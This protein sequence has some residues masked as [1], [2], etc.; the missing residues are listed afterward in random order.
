MKK[1]YLLVKLLALAAALS[2]CSIHHYIAEDY[3]QYLANNQG[4][5][6]L[7]HATV[8]D[9]SYF[10]TPNTQQHKY[11][12]RSA[13][14]GYANAWVVEFGKMLDQTLQGKDVQDAFGKLSKSADD[15][16]PSGSL[17]TFDLTHYSYDDFKAHV[18]LKI[19]LKQNGVERLSKTYTAEGNR[20]QGKMYW[21]GAF[22][23]KNATQQSTK[24]AIDDI[25]RHFIV[26]LNALKR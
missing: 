17:I 15:N 23:M 24:A 9:A 22:A 1:L 14:A 25:L 7:P 4:T 20:Q 13:L 2:A 6:A 19:S 26:D 10:L 8:Q 12:F 16:K 5:N 18:G 11:E 3:P 21:G